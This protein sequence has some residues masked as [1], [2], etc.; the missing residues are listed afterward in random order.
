MV[1]MWTYLARLY[2]PKAEFNASQTITIGEN[3]A[4]KRLIPNGCAK[5]NRTRMV[6]VT[7]IIVD[8]EMF[9][10][11]SF[12]PCTAPRTDCAGVNTPSAIAIDT[13]KTPMACRR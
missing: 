1:E 12:K 6:Q 2:I 10:L 7:P 13:A 8:L 3:A 5:N 9:L 4:E 11:I